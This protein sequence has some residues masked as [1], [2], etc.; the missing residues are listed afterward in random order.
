MAGALLA[1]L[2]P[3]GTQAD[4]ALERRYYDVRGTTAGELAAGITARSPLGVTALTELAPT[5]IILRPRRVSG[6]YVV[7]DLR[8]D[9]VIIQTLPRWVDRD[10]ARPCLQREW[11]R[12]MAALIRH[13]DTHRRRYEEYVARLRQEALALPP[14]PS[15]GALFSAVARLNKRLEEETVAWQQ[16]YDRRTQHGRAEGVFIRGC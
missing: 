13:E 9:D 14:Q 5:R 7:G 3:A 11:D 6:G 2:L 15:A 4:G 8:F 1:A 16:D 12:A 10:R